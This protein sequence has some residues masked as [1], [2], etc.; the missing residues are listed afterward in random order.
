MWFITMMR[1]ATHGFC[2]EQADKGISQGG[3][4]I[5]Q[6]IIAFD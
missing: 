1:Q 4:K 3:Q 6:Y 2:W 5:H